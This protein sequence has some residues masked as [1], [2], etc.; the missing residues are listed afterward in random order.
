MIGLGFALRGTL[1][2]SLPLEREAFIELLRE[3]WA[4]Q[5]EP[6]RAG[7][8][9]EAANELFPAGTGEIVKPARLA[10]RAAGLLGRSMQG[11][12]LVIRFRQIA[13]GIAARSIAASAET[14]QLLD[15]IDSLGIPTAVLCNGWSRIAQREAACAGFTGRVLI[16]EDIGVEKPARA[17]FDALANAL[18]L[19]ADR[20]W[21]V[22]DDP[23]RD[24]HGAAAA[25]MT[26]V[27]LN[28]ANAP[29]PSGLEPPARTIARLADL[30]PPVCE[31]YTRSL[32]S[33]RHVMRTALEWR[34]GH[35]VPPVERQ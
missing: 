25:G 3:R 26:A 9:T 27:W 32:L 17:A 15:R 23:I 30:L 1:T 29:Y 2:A 12:F 20:I 18:G 16:S 7:D 31:E 6:F 13:D 33:L 34:E 14:R 4:E 21:Y 8:A 10:D 28:A 11:S 35:Y 19:P 22:G 24:I 5:G